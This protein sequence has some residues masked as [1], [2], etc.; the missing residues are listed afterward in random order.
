M[1]TDFRDLANSLVN[2]KQFHLPA[3]DTWRMGVVAGYDPAYN[4]DSA[5][6][7][8]PAVSVRLAGDER[9]MHGFRFSEHYI[10]NLGDTVWVVI[11]PDDGWVMGSLHNHAS[12]TG[13]KRSPMTLL[14]QASAIGTTNPVVVAP[15]LPNRLYRIEGQV[16][17]TTT[18][19]SANS[20][21][22][23]TAYPAGSVVTYGG[24]YYQASTALSGNW[25]VLTT[26]QVG[27][28][29]RSTD[30]GYYVCLVK[31]LGGSAPTATSATW[32]QTGVSAASPSA[33][34]WTQSTSAVPV[35]QMILKVSQPGSS[36]PLVLGTRD[37]QS[38][39]SY[40]MTGIQQWSA[41][42]S[43]LWSNNAWTTH[44]PNSQYAWTLEV[45]SLSANHSQVNVASS[46]IGIYDM[47]V[48][49]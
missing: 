30:N 16:S 21:S 36:S 3:V 17:F 42:N 34:Y 7:G 25:S 5:S 10:P 20:Y 35:G 24:N 22:S 11:S 45:N 48:A 13:G 23:T 44:Y 29:I 47:G 8:Y 14:G 38:N 46:Q 33:P 41:T 39:S 15:I 49:T 19:G 27:Q 12:N 28:I 31:S 18:T 4:F 2:N 26:Y 9:M 43:A 37:V 40:Q 6:G 32:S 1:G